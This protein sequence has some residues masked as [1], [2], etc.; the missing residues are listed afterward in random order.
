MAYYLRKIKKQFADYSLSRIF[1]IPDAIEDRAHFDP[2]QWWGTYGA[3]T[4]E[5]K[6]LAFKLLGQPASSS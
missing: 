5:L 3:R 2:L 6:E 1:A 4:P